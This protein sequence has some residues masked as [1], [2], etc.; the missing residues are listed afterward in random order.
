MALT[1][2]AIRNA[3][4]AAKPYKLGD[5][6]GLFLHVATSGGKLWR[7]KYRFNGTEKLLSYGPYPIVTL[8]E[9]R[10]RRDASKKLLNAGI[11][12]SEAKKVAARENAGA[13]AQTFGLLAKEYLSKLEK[14]GRAPT[15]VNKTRWLLEDLAG[16]LAKRPI[17]KLTPAEVLAVLRPLEAR[18]VHETAL[19]LRSAIGRLARYAIATGRATNDPTSAL[20]GALQTPRVR[21]RAAITKPEYVGQLLRA[22]DGFEG[23]AVVGAALKIM[24][25][26]F[27]RPGELRFA[28]WSE[29]DL[30]KAVWSIPAERAKMRRP[31]IIALPPQ[32]VAVLRDL[33]A[34]SG[35]GRL[36]FPG[37][38]RAA[39]PLS[40]NTLNAA[41]RRMGYTTD[42]MTAHGFRTVASTLLNESG[43]W[44]ADAIERALAHQDRNAIRRAYARGEFWDERVKM[45][46]WWADYLDGLQ[47]GHALVQAD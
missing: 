16:S 8:A 9:A 23:Y 19:R 18:G 20:R 33:H 4:P 13:A 30:D 25:L 15:T 34:I 40:E 22:I 10:E 14:E 39:V 12:P 26:C 47:A 27:P 32:A 28:E 3:K 45:A 46:A 11:D 5:S 17:A 36:V 38:R 2:V 21:H 6:G 41:L 43:L 42:E 37:I 31:H 35:T 24:A 1:D 29:I 44:S 7:L